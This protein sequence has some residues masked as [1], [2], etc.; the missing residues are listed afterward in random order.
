MKACMCQIKKVRKVQK[1][2]KSDFCTFRTPITLRV[3]KDALRGEEPCM[4]SRP[5]L[6]AMKV[7]MREGSMGTDGTTEKI[8]ETLP[9]EGCER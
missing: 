6:E 8:L 7:T 2:Y 9:S 3:Q 4:S 1:G 5:W